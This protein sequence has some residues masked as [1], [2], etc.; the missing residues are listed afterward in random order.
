MNRIILSDSHKVQIFPAEG[1]VTLKKN[2]DFD[3]SGVVSAGKAEYY[4]KGFSFKYNDFQ[5]EMPIIDSLQLWADTEKRTQDGVMLEARVQTV[6]EDL[7]GNLKIDQPGNKS[8]LKSIKKYPIFTSE[9]ESYA[10]YDQSN[11]HGGVY[12]RD[13]FY[14]QL[15]PFVLDSLD[16]F[17][18]KSIKLKG[19]FVSA[20]IFP[21]ME[22]VL[23]LQPDYSLGF[24]RKTPDSGL[25][26]YG[27]KG[28][29]KNDINLSNRGLRGDGFIE[30]I[31]ATAESKSF[32]F[33][34]DSVNGVTRQVDIEEQLGAVEY[35]A[36]SADTTFLHWM[37]YRDY[38]DISSMEGKSPIDMYAGTS[39]H[40]GTLRYSPNELIGWGKNSFEGANL[41]SNKMV[42]K[43]YQL[44]SDTCDFEL[45][46]ELFGDINFSSEN[47]NAEVDFQKREGTF[48]SNT[49]ASL[50]KFGETQ[51]QAYL[52]RFT[53]K[54]D[55]AEIEY[56]SEGQIVKQGAEDIKVEGAE[57]VSIH[58]KQDSLRWF[59]KAATYSVRDVRITAREVENID[60]AD[61]SVIPGDGI[62]VVN[63]NARMN[64]LDSARVIANRRT[65]YHNVYDATVDITGR[66]AY[67]GTG[68]Y[69]Y[70]DEN[71]LVQMIT[72][73]TITVDS[74]KQS[75][76]EGVIPEEQ[77]F[78]LSPRFSFKGDVRLEANEKNLMFSGASQI[79][80]ACEDL[81]KQWFRFR[82]RI[83]P[84]DINIEITPDAK[85]EAGEEI[86]SSL[87]IPIDDSVG[88]YSTFLSQPYS[89]VDLEVLDSKGFLVFDKPTKEFRISSFEKLNERSLP[90][91]YIALNTETCVTEGEGRLNFAHRTSHVQVQPAGR[92]EF[93]TVNKE[94]SADLVVKFEFLFDDN[95]FDIIVKELQASESAEPVDVERAIYPIA[96]RDLVGKEAADELLGRMSLGRSAKL[97]DELRGEE[98]SAMVF[99]DV[100]LTYD[101]ELAMYVAKDKIGIG[102][103]G[104][105]LLNVYVKGGISFETKRQGTD[106]MIYLDLDKY[107]YIF[108]YRASS[109]I[110]QV[111][112]NNDEFKAAVNEIKND[113]R[114]IKASKTNKQYIFQ[115]G[116][117]TLR[118]KALNRFESIE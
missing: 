71:G 6:I 10:Y 14:F 68:M 93:N 108:Y 73:N 34:P 1:K 90:G 102:N 29:F 9:K 86:S 80:H 89:K 45:G 2:R 62:V 5:I 70:K 112:S 22:E 65:K 23:V 15:E 115:V 105:E 13:K 53:W 46:A 43:F 97:P 50:T 16:K 24:T 56:S 96:L 8:G 57:F 106:F 101:P 69:D 88:I 28:I 44:L 7:R 114:R 52:D 27:G 81:P 87:M 59:A 92:Y 107:Y 85:N 94:L 113:K 72:L 20:G 35:P 37:P 60:V 18:N 75:F 76:A 110:M 36:V 17:E 82:S 98:H 40:E 111:Y 48:V 32:Y 63:K 67:K 66:F 74:S 51:Y 38:M 77:S 99:S 26:A 19:A 79:I 33:F 42:F 91:N 11:V 116:S 118:S 25:P 117:K 61:A 103:I 109:G 31:T 64:T 3:F 4:G 104:K 41:Y 58:P 55:A 30:Y 39:K 84:E 83:D 47:L 49:G 78:S 21:D 100:Q 12:N 54:M 95:L